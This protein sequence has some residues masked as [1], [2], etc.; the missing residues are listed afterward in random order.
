MSIIKTTIYSNT[1]D[2]CV[3]SNNIS[4]YLNEHKNYRGL[5]TEDY[6][7]KV[8]TSEKQRVPNDFL[9]KIIFIS[10][11]SFQQ[12]NKQMAHKIRN[13]I[14]DI[15]IS[16]NSLICIGGESY[17]YGMVLIQGNIYHLTNSKAIYDDVNYN[18]QFYNK[19]IANK[20]VDYN[21]ENQIT[22]PSNY[23]YCIINLSRLNINLIKKLNCCYLKKI[24]I[25]NCHHDD[26][27]KK[28]KYLTN[29]TLIKRKRFIDYKIGYFVTVN[30]FVH[31]DNY[32]SLGSNCA[33][34]WNLKRYKLRHMSLPFDWANTKISNL[35]DVLQNNF[36]VYEK[37]KI[38]KYSDN[39]QSLITNKGTFIVKNKYDITFAHEILK[40]D[41]IDMFSIKLLDRI[42]KFKSL[43]FPTFIRLEM[44]NVNKI[45]YLELVNTIKKYFNDFI[46]ILISHENP[47]IKHIKHI[48]LNDFIDWRY[49]NFN[50]LYLFTNF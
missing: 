27:W 32:I 44:A 7:G 50:W 5:I 31:K 29:Y 19:V 39:H 13:Y 47:N 40:N 2:K 25:I 24:I 48:Y 28:I 49:E 12:N 34:A 6:L 20:L 21:D 36:S 16:F 38:K 45:K 22:I 46:F 3:L 41:N 9:N 33:V 35:I 17:M 37:I 42:E 43:K 23:Y 18:L 26:F 14:K 15:I 10:L 30:I 1:Y 11:S 4:N 8:Y